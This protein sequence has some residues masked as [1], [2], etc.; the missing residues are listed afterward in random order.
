MWK[1]FA[2]LE[3]WQKASLIGAALGPTWFVFERLPGY[4]D[5]THP[6][7]LG[8]LA[9]DLGFMAGFYLATLWRGAATT[10]TTTSSPR[11]GPCTSI[12]AWEAEWRYFS[13]STSREKRFRTPCCSW[14]RYLGRPSARCEGPARLASGPG[15]RTPR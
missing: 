4:V 15:R 1:W 8:A 3:G 12:G 13:A 5:G 6:A 14:S 10:L 7:T 11:R 2:A 9:G